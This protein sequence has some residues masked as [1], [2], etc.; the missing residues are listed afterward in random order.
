MKDLTGELLERFPAIPPSYFSRHRYYSFESILD[1]IAHANDGTQPSHKSITG[2]CDFPCEFINTGNRSYILDETNNLP[3]AY[4]KE[5]TQLSLLSEIRLLPLR[6]FVF[7]TLNP[8]CLTPGGILHLIDISPGESDGFN[9]GNSPT[10]PLITGDI[11]PFILS[12]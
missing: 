9:E 8:L 11:S 2:L 5:N 1:I 12:S 6:G 7:K 4:N 10:T 3:T